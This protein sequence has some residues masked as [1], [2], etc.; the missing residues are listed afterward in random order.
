MFN[1]FPFV[2]EY[3]EADERKSTCLPKT[4]TQSI[5]HT[6]GIKLPSKTSY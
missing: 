3:K 6:L 2:Q 4:K 5:G 1:D